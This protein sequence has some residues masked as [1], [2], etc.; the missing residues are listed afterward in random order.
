MIGQVPRCG[1]S[2]TVARPAAGGP[3]RK[4][5][6]CS[7]EGPEWCLIRRSR[8]EGSHACGIVSARNRSRVPMDCGGLRAIKADA[9]LRLLQEPRPTDL[10]D[11]ERRPHALHRLDAA[12]VEAVVE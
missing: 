3:M 9:R 10:P 2:L 11:E 4:P 7:P 5:N 6:R 12:L 1:V 8:R